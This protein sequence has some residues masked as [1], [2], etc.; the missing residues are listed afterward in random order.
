MDSLFT[1]GIA[2]DDAFTNPNDINPSCFITGTHN[3]THETI[4]WHH[5][6]A[7]LNI[8]FV[9]GI[10]TKTLPFMPIIPYFMHLPFYEGY[11]MGKHHKD[12]FSPI[13]H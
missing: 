6:L 10:Q 4:R 12:S 9:K 1:V 2:F 13:S 11:I 8:L 5:R 3:N 7:H